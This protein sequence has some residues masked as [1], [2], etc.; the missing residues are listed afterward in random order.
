MSRVI[1]ADWTWTGA[2]FESGIRLAIDEDGRFAVSESDREP[3]ERWN[4]KALMPGFVNA[5]SHAFQR[6]LRGQGEHFPEG[7][8]SFW[9]WRE[10][11]YGLVES[12]D[13]ERIFEISR[14]CFEEMVRA[15]ITEVGEFHYVHHFRE[16]DWKLDE[17]LLR[18]ARDVGIRISLLLAYYRSG[19]IEKPLTGAQKR[20]AVR[21]PEEYWNAF[22]RLSEHLD[23]ATQ[24]LGCVVHSIRAA[25]LDELAEVHAEAR[26]RGVVF[27]MHVE[28]QR[29]EIEDSVA[30]FGA[31]PMRLLLDRLEIDSSF[32]AV[33]CTHTS[34][35]DLRALFDTGANACICPLTEANLGDGIPPTGL[36]DG[37]HAIALG[38][39]SNA[40]ISFFEEMRWLE[41]VQ[42][43]AGERRGVV[44][45]GAGRSAERLIEIATSGGARSLRGE[46]R[47]LRPG[48]PA[49][50]ICIDL[51]ATSLGGGDGTRL[52]SSLVFGAGND[53]IEGVYVGGRRL[54]GAEG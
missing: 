35:D 43:L 22:Q 51:G 19:G 34:P 14:L 5:H 11:M 7:S 45:D 42:R 36:F 28:E 37:K 53:V 9:T 1:E 15:G 12:L 47:D 39:D 2:G 10:A 23:P 44:L 18:A 54:H 29:Q 38:T 48:A 4:G 49:D 40:R 50:F 46:A 27:H 33:H 31:P 41:Y 52:A 30:A 25:P 16:G 8:G 32:T 21:S 24:S 6:G 26:R 13:D 17:V 3:D 20:F